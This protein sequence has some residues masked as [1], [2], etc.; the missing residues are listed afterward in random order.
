MGIDEM[1][2]AESARIWEEINTEKEICRTDIAY[3]LGQAWDSLTDAYAEMGDAAYGTEGHPVYDEIC[4]L[5]SDLDGL[6]SAIQ[7]LRERLEK[8]AKSA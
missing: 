1:Y 6:E 4:S 7:K 8:E 5:M 3:H 2:E